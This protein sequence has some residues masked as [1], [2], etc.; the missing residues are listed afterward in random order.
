M[1][2]AKAFFHLTKQRNQASRFFA[3]LF[4]SP[5]HQGRESKFQQSTD[6]R[7]RSFVKKLIETGAHRARLSS[8]QTENSIS[9]LNSI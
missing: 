8:L 3:F 6:F 2:R 7:V 5:H 1:G 4:P 9:A